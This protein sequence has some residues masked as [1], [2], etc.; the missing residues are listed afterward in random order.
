[1]QRQH[2]FNCDN[3]LLGICN[4][5]TDKLYF[6]VQ[7]FIVR[8]KQI[9]GLTASSGFTNESSQMLTFAQD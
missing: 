1:M 7:F 2:Y 3:R 5:K 4:I 6:I 8:F 9:E